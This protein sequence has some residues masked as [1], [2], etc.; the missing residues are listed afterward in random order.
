MLKKTLFSILCIVFISF[1][2]NDYVWTETTQEDFKDGTYEKNIYA[3]HLDGGTVEFA[4]RFDLNNDGY[5]DLFTADRSGPYVKIFWGSA[6]GYSS[7]NRTLFPSAGAGNCDAADLNCDGYVDFLVAHSHEYKI[8]IYWGNATG[9]DPSNYFDIQLLQYDGEACFIVD[10]NKDGYLDI[11]IDRA[12]LGYGAILWG[13]ATGY[14]FNNRTDLPCE[15]GQHNIEVADFN[16]DNWLDILFNDLNDDKIYWGSATGFMPANVT[17]LPHFYSSHGAS[18]ADLDGNEYLDIII[19]HWYDI[20]SYVYWGDSIGYSTSNMQI[21]NP[22]YCYGGSSV[23]DINTDGY[24]DIIYHRGGYGSTPQR[25][26]WGSATGYSDNDTTWFGISI[27]ASGGL[28]ADLNFDGDLDVFS[29]TITPGSFS[30]IFWGP[31]F[32]TNTPLPVDSDHHGMFREIGN[33]YNR[34]YY[35]DYISSVFDA[36]GITDWGAI[37]WDASLP[38]ATSI[39]FWVRSGDSP[40][41]DASWSDWYSVY[42]GDSI[43]DDLNA[44]Y[45]QYKAQL[46]FTN[47]CYLPSLDE[48]RVT[49]TSSGMI[50][51]S[52]DIKPEVINLN[53]HGKFTAFLILPAGYDPHEIDVETVEC[54]G[55]IALSGHVT[56]QRFIAKFA[57]QDLVGVT[58]GPAVEF[59]VTGQ[60]FDGTPFCGYDTVRVIGHDVTAVVLSCTPNP[61]RDRTE[62]RFQITDDRLQMEDISFKIYNVTGRLVRQWD[63][64][65]IG[66]FNQVIWDRKDKIGRKVPSGVYL[67]KA[68]TE[69]IS[70]IKKVVVLD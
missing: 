26:Y 2:D 32:S 57:V 16:K 25:I 36:A 56:A 14:D 10:F 61:F 30:Y 42:N 9:P 65:A 47:P 44:R 23:A 37:E 31:S 38:C 46:A 58:P 66:S 3:S 67:L 63:Y 19:T 64:P 49:Y 28:V 35:E 43:P 50:S 21:L 59:M 52:V 45:L 40:T 39:L 11:A 55:A 41:P 15:H 22:G 13:S 53:S 18:V 48:V 8:S 20:Q 34:E 27:E 1:A 70:I 17:I 7:N 6:T 24:L 54:E 51:A 69:D 4:P 68:Q 33:V 62:I 60:L 29:N 5:I 12:I